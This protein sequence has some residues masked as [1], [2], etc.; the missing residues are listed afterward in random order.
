MKNF[1]CLLFVLISLSGY[2]QKRYKKVYPYGKYQPNWAMV[3]TIAGTYGFIDREGNEVVPAIYAK[4][5]KFNEGSNFM[6]V[7]SIT[8]THGLINAEGRLIVPAIYEKIE[9]AD[10]PGK[11]FA[12]LKTIHG[13][14][15]MIDEDGNEILSFRPLDPE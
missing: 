12:T 9:P 11:I 6:L 3:K 2:A 14:Y 4:I 1:V 8:D 15:K 13:T 7:K 5:R 10:P